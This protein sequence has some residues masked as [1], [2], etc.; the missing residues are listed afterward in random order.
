MGRNLPSWREEGSRFYTQN[1]PAQPPFE[2]WLCALPGGYKAHFL[3]PVLSWQLA[4]T[5]ELATFIQGRTGKCSQSP[6]LL[7]GQLKAWEYILTLLKPVAG[8]LWIS[9]MPV[10]HLLRARR[11]RAVNCNTTKKSL[12]LLMKK[13]LE[14]KVESIPNTL[15]GCCIAKRCGLAQVY[16]LAWP[17]WHWGSLDAAQSLGPSCF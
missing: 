2:Q 4:A 1:T 11:G 15:S 14:I 6:T 13:E 8:L 7:N 5:P 17:A 9:A 3:L 12:C 16:V 10:L